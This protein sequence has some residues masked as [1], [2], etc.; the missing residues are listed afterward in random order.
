MATQ[1]KQQESLGGTAGDEKDTLSDCGSLMSEQ[2]AEFIA[3][4][5][6]PNSPWTRKSNPKIYYSVK[7]G[8]TDFHKIIVDALCR[9]VVQG[10]SPIRVNIYQENPSAGLISLTI[11][12][13]SA[14]VKP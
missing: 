14:S 11:I 2:G 8:K 10:Q 6:L 5:L 1:V 9:G 7:A 13:S 4:D 12:R 3:L